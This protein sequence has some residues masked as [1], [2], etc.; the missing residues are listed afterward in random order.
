MSS[1]DS[2]V[3]SALV[4]QVETMARESGIPGEPFCART[5]VEEWLGRSCPALGNRRPMECLEYPEGQ[6]AIENLLAQMQSGAYA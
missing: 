5:W 2:A 1:I 3:L 6:Q 4:H